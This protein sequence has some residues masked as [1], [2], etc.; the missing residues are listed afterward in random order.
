M[1][2][3]DKQRVFDRFWR[4]AP[5]SRDGR[6]GLGLAIVR[7]IIESHRGQL[8]VFSALGE[9]ATFVLWLPAGDRTD[10]DPPPTTSP[11][12]ASG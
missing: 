3:G 5:E 9:G 11:L 4:R 2:A 8:A 10:D 7:Q 6:T 1:A 12:T